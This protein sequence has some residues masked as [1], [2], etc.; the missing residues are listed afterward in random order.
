MRSYLRL[1]ASVLFFGGLGIALAATMNALNDDAFVKAG[2]ALARHPDHVIFQGEYY[3]ALARHIAYI[4]TAIVA[5]LLG[6]VASAIL[7]G[8][9]AVL[10]RMDELEAA[11]SDRTR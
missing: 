2:E 9:Y 5:G 6:S 4:T 11:L 3:A 1:M 8:L 7:F 10:R